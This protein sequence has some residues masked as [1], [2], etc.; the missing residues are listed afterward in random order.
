MLCPSQS[1]ALPSL[2]STKSWPGGRWAGRGMVMTWT[3]CGDVCAVP[4]AVL[5][6][7]T[8]TL[9]PKP[10]IK[11]S[12]GGQQAGTMMVSTQSMSAYSHRGDERKEE[13]KDTHLTPLSG[14]G[15]ANRVGE[16]CRVRRVNAAGL[17]PR[18]HR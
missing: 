10:N 17:I 2:F 6:T 18:Q 11:P 7:A 4:I 14:V 5:C 8:Q 13:R 12:S 1:F 16:Q 9:H 15:F 3:R